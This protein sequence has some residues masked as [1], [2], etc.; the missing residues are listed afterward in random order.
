[1]KRF[2]IIALTVIAVGIYLSSG[3]KPGPSNESARTP[4]P[5][6][7]TDEMQ[8]V[9]QPPSAEVID[10]PGS[11]PPVGEIPAYVPPPPPR[12]DEIPGNELPPDSPVDHPRAGKATSDVS[13]ITAPTALKMKADREGRIHH[14]EGGE[15]TLT[16]TLLTFA[17]PSKSKLSVNF[18]VS[19]V[20]K[21]DRNGVELYSGAQYHFDIPNR[22][23]DEIANMFQQWK[24][25]GSTGSMIPRH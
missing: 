12:E 16:A 6:P 10:H 22:N 15:L 1:M 13:P 2:L 7:A 4:E 3:S 23:S 18:N 5:A 19:Q 21:I 17:C 14:C 25:K 20:K 8:P 11:Q 24:D 9:N